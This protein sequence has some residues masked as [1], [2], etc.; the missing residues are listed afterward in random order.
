MARATRNS[1]GLFCR[2]MVRI[3][4]SSRRT[5]RAI[6]SCSVN[7]GVLAAGTLKMTVSVSALLDAGRDQR[8]LAAARHR[9]AGQVDYATEM[10]SQSRHSPIQLCGINRRG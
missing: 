1:R 10:A 6:R 2:M 7:K 8:F 3:A 9:Y 4:A 5:A